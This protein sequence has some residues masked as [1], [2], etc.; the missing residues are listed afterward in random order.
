MVTT[1]SSVGDNPTKDPLAAI[2]TKLDVLDA[3]K[4]KVIALE[5]QASKSYRGKGKARQW[6]DDFEDEPDFRRLRPPRAKVDF[7]KF[8]GG[9]PLG[10]LKLKSTFGTMKHRMMIRWTELRC[11]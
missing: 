7:P 11:T 5:E 8:Q 6:V 10:S 3:L 9:D 4:E 2:A 1:H